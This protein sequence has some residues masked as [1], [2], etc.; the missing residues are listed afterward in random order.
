[1]AR[2]RLHQ[3][4]FQKT[5]VLYILRKIHP[6]TRVG[7]VGFVLSLAADYCLIYTTPAGLWNSM[8]SVVEQE[9]VLGLQTA[10]IVLVLIGWGMNIYRQVK[11]GRKPS[12]SVTKSRG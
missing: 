8:R 7:G 4:G 9:V 12:G 3:T 1:V 10:S 5:R 2:T 11:A 6:L